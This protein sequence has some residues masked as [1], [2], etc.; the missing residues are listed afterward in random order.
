MDINDDIL[1]MSKGWIIHYNDGRTITEYDKD[2]N[3]T[4]WRL[5][6]KKD[7]KSLSLK[8]FNK[9]WSIYGKQDYLQ[10]KKG[11]ITPIHG[12][13]QEPNIQFRYIGYWEGNNKVFYRVDEATGDMKMV[14]ESIAGE[15]EEV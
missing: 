11:W 1:N 14:V 6:P 12:L 15:E 9:H 7:I 8:W 5:A 3:Q 13:E 4:E 10:K 2:G